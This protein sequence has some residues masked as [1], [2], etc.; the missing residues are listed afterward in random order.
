MI[1]L[2]P[3]YT[4]PGSNRWREWP[5]SNRVAPSDNWNLGH[6]RE[7]W[8]DPPRGTW[9]CHH[10]RTA[11]AAAPRQGTIDRHHGSETRRQ[12]RA[13]YVG[14]DCCRPEGRQFISADLWDYG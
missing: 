11:A 1:V 10:A 4:A 8:T 2:H 7:Q 9:R 12:G 14:T 6:D 5:R 3:G 13:L